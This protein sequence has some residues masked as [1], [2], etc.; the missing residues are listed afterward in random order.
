MKSAIPY[1][2]LLL[3]LGAI[4]VCNSQNA[5]IP[6]A[7]ASADHKRAHPLTDALNAGF[8]GISA[9]IALN[10]EGQLKCGSKYLEDLYFKPLLDL[11][12]N[13]NGWIY[14]GTPEEFVLFLTI[15]ADSV[16]T[17]K[18]LRKLM[19]SYASIITQ[20]TGATRTKKAVRVIISGEIPSSQIQSESTRFC[21]L[22]EPIQKTGKAGGNTA[23]SFA[24]L[25]FNK[26]YNWSGDGNMTNTEYYSM[27]TFVKLAH[28]SGRLV[29]V[30]RIPE[31][32][33]AFNL[34]ANAGVDFFEVN[35]ID[36]FIR[37][38]RNRH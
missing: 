31:K 17:Y 7:I 24:T 38:R 18:T 2:I 6:N 5:Y 19:E 28:K 1:I 15:K 13:N 37:Y 30:I 35:D 29:R 22:D 33:N 23:Y 12:K 27:T 11:A 32:E 20:Y 25:N 8:A 16:E 14:P 34:L 26:N 4:N 10:K 21:S 9:E 36:N 3:I